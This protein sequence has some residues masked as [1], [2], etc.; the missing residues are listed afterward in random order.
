DRLPD[1]EA[2][3]DRGR[4]SVGEAHLVVC[5]VAV[6]SIEAWTLGAPSALAGH[7][8]VEV[9]AVCKL[10]HLNQVET[11]KETSEKREKQPKAILQ[12][13]AGLGNQND[14]TDLRV[15]VAERVDVDELK[16]HC[17]DGFKPF[18]DA[19]VT[20]FGGPP[21]VQEDEE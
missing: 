6:E 11:F 15:C 2:G 4:G 20:A 10:Y 5:G 16:R 3:R 13:V 19:L 9:S 21:E 1:M 8:E 18:A 7:L 17:K 14:S 12:Q